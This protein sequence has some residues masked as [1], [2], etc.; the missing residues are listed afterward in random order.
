MPLPGI[1]ASQISGHLWAPSG[2]YDALASVTLSAA[3]ASITFAGIPSGYKH[4]QIRSNVLLQTANEALLMRA[5]GDTNNNYFDHYLYGTGSGSALSSASV[6]AAYYYVNSGLSDTYPGGSITDILDYGVS[7]K[8]K[9]L[10]SLAGVDKNGSGYIWLF[11]GTWAN[12]APITSLTIYAGN[13]NINANSSFALY[14][15]K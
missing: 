14:G 3:T 13:G 5:N 9:T 11:S 7:T 4:L 2:A 1:Y 12:T 15:V 10:R 6:P 8:Y